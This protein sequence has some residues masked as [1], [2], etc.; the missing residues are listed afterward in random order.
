LTLMVYELAVDR[1]GKQ[2]YLAGRKL[3]GGG[4][5]LL[6]VWHDTTTLFTT[7][8]EGTSAVGP[9]VGAGILRLRPS[10]LVG[11]VATFTT[12]N[13]IGLERARVSSRFLRFF[14]SEVWNVYSGR[15][16]AAA[17]REP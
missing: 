1:D 5:S 9:V 6:S 15:R 7:L 17:G 13:A 12:I 11:L 2:Y 10:A 14:S 4:H 16:G 3:V 8:H